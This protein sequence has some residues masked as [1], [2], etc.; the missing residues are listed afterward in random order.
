MTLRLI[1]SRCSIYTA[2]KILRTRQVKRK[3]LRSLLRCR[4]YCTSSSHEISFRE[5]LQSYGEGSVDLTKDETDGIAVITLNNPNKKNAVSGK[6]ML[7]FR[8]V[9]EDL[10]AWDDGKGVILT[11]SQGTFCSGGDLTTVQNILTPEQGYQMADFMHET[12]TRL[13]CLPL[14]SMALVQGNAI[15]GGAELTTACDFRVMTNTARI[16]FVHMK[17]GVLTGWGGATRLVRLVGRS[18]SL[19]MLCSSRLLSS[20]ECLRQGLAD[21]II[22]IQT[23]KKESVEDHDDVM[24]IG[25]AWLSQYCRADRQLVRD[26]KTAVLGACELDYMSSLE[27]ERAIFN[28]TWGGPAHKRALDL[29][30]KHS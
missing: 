26:M 7:D 11:G 21:H 6:M 13:H 10:E 23:P 2:E 25:R 5:R 9:V 27:R 22:P 14:I 1:S 17:M 18:H 8:N 19:D 3:P 16:G 24:K 15:G 30:I 29:N 20:Q 12:L 4:P 28:R